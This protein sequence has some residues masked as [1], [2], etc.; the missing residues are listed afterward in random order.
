MTLPAWVR[1]RNGT[2][3]RF[4]PDK[5]SPA[6]FAAAE[7]LGQPNA[8]LARELADGVVHFLAA[9][10]AEQPPTTTQIAESVV[11][12]VRELGH[13]ALAQAFADGARIRARR[14]QPETMPAADSEL[15]RLLV[16]YSPSA[17]QEE[18]TAA[19]NRAFALQ[20]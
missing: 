19:C 8:F 6:L 20:Q 16:P 7:N 10:S 9:E 1:K 15:A 4:D 11:K 13:P 5:I 3:V 12:T 18:L 2:L 17:S 14:H